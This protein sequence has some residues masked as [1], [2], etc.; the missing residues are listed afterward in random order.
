MVKGKG[1]NKE[2][3]TIIVTGHSL[4]AAMATITATRIS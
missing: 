1:A 3:D 2:R 4:G